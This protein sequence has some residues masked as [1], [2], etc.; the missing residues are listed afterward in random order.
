MEHFDELKKEIKKTTENHAE[1]INQLGKE[2]KK[3]NENMAA[4]EKR[5]EQILEIL[6]RF[7]YSFQNST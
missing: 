1:K 2:I 3:A 7:Q 6:E 4:T 5:I